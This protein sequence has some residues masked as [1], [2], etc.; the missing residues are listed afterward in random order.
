MSSLH[1]VTQ[2]SFVADVLQSDVPV[3]GDFYANWCG[4]CRIPAAT[5]SRLS[6]EF[7]GRVKVV[8]V[9]VESELQLAARYE[10]DSIPTLVFFR[11]GE[12][13]GKIAGLSR[14]AGLGQMLEK[15]TGAAPAANGASST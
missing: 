4:P 7:A 1:Q 2:A 8:K 6:D 10:V 9:N 3:R 11:G 15:L 14:D 5:L 13:V 12:V